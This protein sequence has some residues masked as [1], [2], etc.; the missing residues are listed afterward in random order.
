[1]TDIELISVR[2]EPQ[3]CSILY[4]LL[5]ERSTEDDPHV[6]ISHRALPT[7]DEHCRFFVSPPYYAWYLIRAGEIPTWAGNPHWAG[8]VSI[9]TRNEI[10]IVLFKRYRGFGIGK[11]AL[12]RLLKL[13]K[14]LPAIPSQRTG[15]FVANINPQ[16]ARSIALFQSLG[17]TLKQ[18]TYGL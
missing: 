1:M 18:H 9:T 8:Y 15:T 16:N 6:N 12:Q 3:A 5:K 11:A 13:Q 14:P 4:E 7:W 2:H 10:G 17:F